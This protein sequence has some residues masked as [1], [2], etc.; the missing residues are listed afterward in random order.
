MFAISKVE[1]NRA[2][3][4]NI[5]K[6]GNRLGQIDQA[7]TG[8]TETGPRT[9][10]FPLPVEFYDIYNNNKNQNHP[11]RFAEKADELHEGPASHEEQRSNYEEADNDFLQQ[12]K[13]Y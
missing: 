5:G 3:F 12:L 6:R 7:M 8:A 1:L 11:D 2:R 9:I 4:N 10:S 13:N